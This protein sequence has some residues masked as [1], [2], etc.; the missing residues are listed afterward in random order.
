M[1]NSLFV[2]AYQSN[3]SVIQHCFSLTKNQLIVISIIAYETNK[4]DWVHVSTWC[5]IVSL[6]IVG[7]WTE[8]KMTGMRTMMCAH[9]QDHRGS[10]EL[11]VSDHRNGSTDHVCGAKTK[12]PL[13][14]FRH[15]GAS[16]PRAC[17]QRALPYPPSI[18]EPI[19]RIIIN[20]LTKI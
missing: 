19:T 5:V 13:V 11:I 16:T 15:T 4:Q 17:V 3:L 12:T 6:R 7:L 14:A 20:Q 9:V 1:L 8:R 10:W 2:W 18:K